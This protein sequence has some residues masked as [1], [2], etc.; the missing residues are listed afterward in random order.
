M[1][2]KSGRAISKLGLGCWPLGGDGWGRQRDVDSEAVLRAAVECGITHFDTA[3][4][5]GRGHGEELIGKVL[6]PVYDSIFVAT[7]IMYTEALNVEAAVS[8]SL[9]RLR[10]DAIDLL[11]IHWPKRTG[12]L[13]AMM[14]ALE[15]LRARGVVRHI[16]VSN[17]SVSQ[18]RDCMQAGTID[19]HQ[20]CYNLMWRRGERETIP[21][22]RQAGITLVTYGS[23]AEGILTGKFGPSPR[24]E[25]GDHRPGT[26]LFDQMVWP[27]VYDAVQELKRIA[28][29]A[30]QPL[31]RLALRW[32]MEKE[33]I[34]SVLTGARSPEQ[35]IDNMKSLEIAAVREVWERF[36]EVSDR[37]Q[38]FIPDE[39][40]IFRWYP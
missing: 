13:Q 33:N 24:F 16:G 8:H 32:L 12:N 19:V 37:L 30:E 2:S 26:V 15:K 28:H 14:S 4:T 18:M 3:Q 40:N 1:L 5:Y 25:G 22:C 20:L 23:L 6:R 9:R 10:T 29:D 36:T 17:F 38:Q 21:F 27:H 35:I 11:Y 39:D 34:V 7:K 31:G